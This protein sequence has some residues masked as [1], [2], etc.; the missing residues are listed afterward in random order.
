MDADSRFAI[1][2]H[3]SGELRLWEISTDD[4]LARAKQ[5]AGR[6]LSHD[7][8]AANQ[9]PSIEAVEAERQV[10]RGDWFFAHSSFEAA[11][12]RDANDLHLRFCVLASHFVKPDPVDLR[13]LLA[14]FRSCR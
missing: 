3:E 14:V 2:G 7:E 6:S 4:L 5:F 8:R 12:R 11:S 9:L 10:E 13:R 1:T